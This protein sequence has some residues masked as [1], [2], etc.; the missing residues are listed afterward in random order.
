MLPVSQER[1]ASGIITHKSL[2]SFISVG[3]YEVPGTKGFIEY[4][5]LIFSQRPRKNLRTCASVERGRMSWGYQGTVLSET[6]ESMC[7]T[8]MGGSRCREMESK[9]LV[10]AVARARGTW[11]EMGMERHQVPDNGMPSQNSF[12]LC[13]FL[14]SSICSWMHVPLTITF[15]FRALPVQG[16]SF[17]SS[18]WFP[19]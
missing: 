13:F 17:S 1:A 14:E 18:D 6:E 2:Q 15:R 19:Y 7:K 9:T 4:G 16:S 3:C 10:A 5:S 8:M 12:Q 11:S